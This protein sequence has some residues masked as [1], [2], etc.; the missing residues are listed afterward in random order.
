MSN[1]TRHWDA[2]DDIKNIEPHT[3]DLQEKWKMI[4]QEKIMQKTNY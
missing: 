1:L 2:G 3:K 4:Q